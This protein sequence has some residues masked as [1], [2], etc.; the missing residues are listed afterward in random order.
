MSQQIAL[1]Y[2]N[3]KLRPRGI[4]N[5]TGNDCWANTAAQL[6]I[7][8][9]AVKCVD[10]PM[11]E[12]NC[13]CGGLHKDNLAKTIRAIANHS[14]AGSFDTNGGLAASIGDHIALVGGQD[15]A[16]V[17]LNA[18]MEHLGATARSLFISTYEFTTKADSCSHA[19]HISKEQVSQIDI[20]RTG[21]LNFADRELAQLILTLDG[22]SEIVD[23]YKCTSCN[24]IGSAVRNIR[25]VAGAQY[26]VVS[27][28]QSESVG[29]PR[30]VSFAQA[31]G[32]TITYVLAGVGVHSSPTPAGLTAA[33]LVRA[34][35][36]HWTAR[37][38]RSS[39]WYEISD[40]VATQISETDVTRCSDGE[41]PRIALYSLSAI[42]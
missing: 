17:G 30:T 41:Y 2:I 28:I 25:L 10:F 34:T 22:D 9:L 33:G 5:S 14:S 36:G 23:G 35:G 4:V 31:D 20:R 18:L 37:V 24:R 15:C 7:T 40:S 32:K 29:F 1:K 19:A 6:Y 26:L 21:R 27:G 39:G 8:T 3:D 11:T 42:Q 16:M 12:P 13:I 38:R